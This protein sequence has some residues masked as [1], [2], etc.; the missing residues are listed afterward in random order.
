MRAVR[1]MQF[2]T[3]ASLVLELAISKSGIGKD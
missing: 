1:D 2:T 3:S